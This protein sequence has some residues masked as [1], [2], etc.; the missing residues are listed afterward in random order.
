M[1]LPVK[2]LEKSQEFFGKIGYTFNPQFSNEK[3]ACMIIEDNHIFYM[4]IT[5]PYFKTFTAKELADRG[6]SIAAINGLSADSR[7]KVDEI[8]NNAIAAGATEAR[9]ADDHG[10]MYARS[11]YD[12]DGHMREFFY[13]DLAAA[14]AAHEPTA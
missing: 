13:M 11:F 6:N 14:Q 4:L 12:L 7:E 10:W 5:E 2:D 1:N 3:A 9:P 8:F